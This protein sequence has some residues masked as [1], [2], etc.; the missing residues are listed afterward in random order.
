MTQSLVPLLIF[1]K[2]L[3][4]ILVLLLFEIGQSSEFCCEIKF[5]SFV[6][7]T[8]GKGAFTPFY[9][10]K[11]LLKTHFHLTFSFSPL[12]GQNDQ[13]TRVLEF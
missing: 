3:L 9:H 1:V 6:S 5:L 11:M 8:K 13:Y 10:F 4:E 12:M 7:F 2:L